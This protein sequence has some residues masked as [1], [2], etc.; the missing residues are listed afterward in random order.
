MDRNKKTKIKL[1]SSTHRASIS[2]GCISEEGPINTVFREGIKPWGDCGMVSEALL[3][4][5]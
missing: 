2:A 1:E 4:L 5:W 3:L